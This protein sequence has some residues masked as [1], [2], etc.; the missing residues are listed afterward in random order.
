MPKYESSANWVIFSS[1]SFGLV[2]SSFFGSLIVK[3]NN[4][5][6]KMPG[7]PQIIKTQRHPA[8]CSF[9]LNIEKNAYNERININKIQDIVNS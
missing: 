2:S 1:S 9:P 7:I 3:N 8:N 5:E 4:T 6:T